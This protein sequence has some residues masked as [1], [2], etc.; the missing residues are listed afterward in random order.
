MSNKRVSVI[1]PVYNEERVIIQCLESLHKQ[2]GVDFE[3]VVVDDGST[4][5]TLDYIHAYRPTSFVLKILTQ[6][7]KGP[8]AARNYAASHAQYDILVFVDAD[9]T[10]EKRFLKQ[11]VMP[12]FAN[13]TRGTFST[14]EYVS[15]WNNVWARCLNINEGWPAK[16]RHPKGTKEN[17]VFR[18]ILKREFERVGGFTPDGY[19]DDWSLGE[20]L[21]Y[22]A[23][24]AAKAVFF[25]DNP[26]NL[27]EIIRHAQ[28]VGKRKYKLGTF[29]NIF[30]LIRASLLLSIVIGIY[31]A[32]LSRTPEFLVYKVIFDIGIFW[33]I[34]KY[35]LIRNGAK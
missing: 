28:W 8:G 33:G 9:M 25:H 17:K 18:A 24:D 19:T 32:I 30:A 3:V 7:H 27:G 34:I 4:D 1:I 15:N 13:K 11:L 20:K 23:V 12:I 29:G 14:S 10:F 16:K 31:K 26:D 5:K 35:L 21:G 22:E 6:N 2:T